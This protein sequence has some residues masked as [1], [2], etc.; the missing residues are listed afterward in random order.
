MISVVTVCRNAAED[1]TQTIESVLSQKSK[2]FEYIIKDGCSTDNTIDVASL[3]EKSFVDK[4]IYYSIVSKPDSGIYNAMNQAIDNC[5]G[6][7]VIY[8]NAGDTFYS[9]DVIENLFSHQYD[10]DAMAIIGA[11]NYVLHKGRHYV[12]TP[13]ANALNDL[14]FCH[15]S[16]FVRREYLK[17]HPFEEKYRIVSDRDM[18]LRMIADKIKIQLSSVIISNY[19]TRGASQNNFKATEAEAELLYQ[20]YN[21]AHKKKSPFIA[22]IK[23]I[24][25]KLFPSI[26]DTMLVLKKCRR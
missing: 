19:N 20:T 15:Q 5:H 10:D 6:E 18:L 3:Y 23:N 2:N 14:D 12:G 11:T 17:N 7:W 8:M 1:I 22:G 4:G 16:V 21:I 9:D 13:R 26:P 25:A 24:I